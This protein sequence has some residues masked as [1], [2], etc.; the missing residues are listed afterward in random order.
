[1]RVPRGIFI[2]TTCSTEDEHVVREPDN[3]R[4]YLLKQLQ[5]GLFMYEAR[6]SGR[7]ARRD[8]L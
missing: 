3:A 2:S 4:L 8:R 1:M 5:S 6:K 7:W